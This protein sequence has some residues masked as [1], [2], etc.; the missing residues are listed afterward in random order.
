[1]ETIEG[2]QE[3]E[4]EIVSREPIT[5][6]EKQKLAKS[7]AK[8]YKEMAKRVDHRTV[9]TKKDIEK[10]KASKNTQ[11]PHS[12]YYQKIPESQESAISKQTQ[13]SSRGLWRILESKSKWMK[14]QSDHR[15]LVTP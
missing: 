4:L 15:L 7:I 3:A 1:M 8:K 14:F 10:M 5:Q 9:T 12:H 6:E 2:L 11:L 13:I